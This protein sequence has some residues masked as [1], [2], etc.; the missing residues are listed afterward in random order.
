MAAPPQLPIVELALDRIPRGPWVYGR[1]VRRPAAEIEPGSRVEVA[2]DQA[3]F[4]G[5]ALYNPDSDIRLRWIARG[6]KTDLDR[7]SEFLLGQLRRADKLRRKGLRLE[8]VTDA[9]RIAH[10]EG[11]DLPGLI[12]DRLGDVLVCEHHALGF[13]RWRADVEGS[14]RQLYPQARAILHRFPDSAQRAEGYTPPA[15]EFADPVET[16]VHEHGLRFPIL[17]GAG[18][19]TGYFCDQR[20]SRQ[21]VAGLAKG[22][23]VWDLCC[24]LGGFAQF[25]AAAGARRVEA[26]DLDEKVLARAEAGARLNDLEVAFHHADVFGFMRSAQADGRQ[27]GVVVLDP[28]KVVR[29]RARLEQGLE[30]YGDLNTLALGCVRPGGF[31]ATF[32]CSGAVELPAFLGVLFASARRAGRDI[33]LLETFGAAAD[34]PQR[35]DFSRSRYLK[36][37]LL[38]VD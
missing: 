36:G 32:S 22:R 34:H 38:A 17:A 11:D 37:A 19:K 25:A 29:G 9:Y 21:R 16:V 7:P 23:E 27:A 6:R 35:P 8:D 24:N 20:D 14:L 13:W 5:H 26:V 4:L 28:H 31:L 3:R 12:V 15:A 30:H 2:D 18:H 33:R 10:A 1:Q